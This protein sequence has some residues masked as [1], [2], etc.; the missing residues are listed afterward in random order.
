[1]D[2]GIYGEGRPDIKVVPITKGV[3]V[4]I[5]ASGYVDSN[6]VV[7]AQTSV[8]AVASELKEG[9][10]E[11]SNNIYLLTW[12]GSRVPSG[13]ILNG[14]EIASTQHGTVRDV[15]GNLHG[16]YDRILDCGGEDRKDQQMIAYMFRNEV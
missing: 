11:G 7:D 15:E 2:E 8:P 12:H 4:E 14:V 9:L 10:Q 6:E 3:A 13:L 5:V 16:T 1:M